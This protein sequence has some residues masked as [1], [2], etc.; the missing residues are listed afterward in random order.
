MIVG[1][2][3]SARRRRRS[4]IV[5]PATAATAPSATHNQDSDMSCAGVD[6]GTVGEA[7][8]AAETGAGSVAMRAACSPAAI[9]AR[10]GLTAVGATEGVRETG[11]VARPT[12]SDG[13]VA[14]GVAAGAGSTMAGASPAVAV[15]GRGVSIMRGRTGTALSV[16][17]GP[18]T[19]VSCVGAG[20]GGSWKSP[21]ACCAAPGTAERARTERSEAEARRIMV[22]SIGNGDTP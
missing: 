8:G 21:A 9:G 10:G 22:E 18:W 14:D 12:G 7:M 15:A 16:S 11:C 4:V 2:A 5:A 17:T 20:A 6:G 1:G 13:D 19:R 3:G